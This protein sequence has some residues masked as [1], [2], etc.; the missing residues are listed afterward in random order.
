MKTNN[1]VCDRN[2]RHKYNRLEIQKW[3][4][5]IFFIHSIM[6]YLIINVM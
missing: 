5:N 2:K 6:E 1:I 3:N 4:C